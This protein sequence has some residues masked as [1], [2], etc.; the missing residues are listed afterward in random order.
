MPAQ[1]SHAQQE[2]NDTVNVHSVPRLLV[3]ND[4]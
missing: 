2:V 3:L 4:L 1:R